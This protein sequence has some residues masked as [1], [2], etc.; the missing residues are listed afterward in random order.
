MLAAGWR[1]SCSLPRPLP[2]T[3]RII[4]TVLSRRRT[5]GSWAD[6]TRRGCRGDW[7]FSEGSTRD[8]DF[9]RL[10]VQ[11]WKGWLN[12]S[13]SK[14]P[15]LRVIEL[16]DVRILKTWILEFFNSS[17]SSNYRCFE[18][19]NPRIFLSFPPFRSLGAA[20]TGKQNLLCLRDCAFEER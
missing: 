14:P 7:N 9:G 5:T 6:V 16:F 10:D 2:T 12:F 20:S 19:V 15:N 3:A 11:R 8:W 18:F 17:Q 1:A 13:L 4:A